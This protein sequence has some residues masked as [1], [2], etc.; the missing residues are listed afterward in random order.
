MKSYRTL[1]NSRITIY[2][3]LVVF[4]AIE[5]GLSKTR[6]MDKKLQRVSGSV[7]IVTRTSNLGPLANTLQ[8]N[9]ICIWNKTAMITI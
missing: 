6:N 7:V 3:T 8:L 1:S 5:R 4:P 2:V 9:D